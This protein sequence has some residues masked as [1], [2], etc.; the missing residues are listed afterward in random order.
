MKNF[1]KVEKIN[2]YIKAIKILTGEV[3]YLI[4]GTQ[5]AILVDTSVG[6]KGLD[7]LV[8]SLTNKPITVLL[9]H[10]H[11]DHAPGAVMFDDVYLNF[12]D[13]KLYQKHSQKAV[14][15]GYL[16]DLLSD[17]DYRVFHD[18]LVPSNPNKEFKP[19]RDGMKFNLGEITVQVYS[20]PGHTSGSM[21]L[22]IP[23]LQILVT[24]DAVNKSTFMFDDEAL[25]VNEYEENLKHVNQL[26]S[27]KYNK[28]FI[29]HHQV[30]VDSDIIQNVIQVC[31]DVLNNQADDQPYEFMSKKVLI[32][33]KADEHFNRLDGIDG[34]IVYSKEKLGG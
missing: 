8:Y 29:I 27:D 7:T 34:N 19:L 15:N 21:T 14:R 24:G 18:Q 13:L 33:K 16:E 17:E 31:D 1:Y 5:K 20:L 28:V 10:G 25:P 9:T 2:S 3:M 26:L 11:V 23:E 12:S 4:E 6:I 32:A 22:L 30:E